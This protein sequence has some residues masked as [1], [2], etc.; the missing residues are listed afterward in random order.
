MRRI[1]GSVVLLPILALL[2]AGPVAAVPPFHDSGTEQSISAFTSSCGPATCT[3]T[4]VDAFTPA[5]DLVVVC[6]SQFTFNVHNG[7]LT[8]EQNGCSEA[9]SD[10]LVIDDLSSASLAPTAVTLFSCNQQRCNEGDTL[11][12]SAEL[13]GFGS[14]FKDSQRFTFNDGT[15]TFK[16]SF[17]GDTRQATGS[18]TIDGDTSDADGSI[19][20]GKFSFSEHCR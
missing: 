12:V 20:T 1:V 16:Q 6:V 17:S 8:S 11:T 10:A 18:I 9:S 5:D 4:F 7:R 19:R 2:L 14:S 13:T 3:D 15:C